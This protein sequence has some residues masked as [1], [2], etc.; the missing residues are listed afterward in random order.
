MADEIVY[1]IKVDTKSGEQAIKKIDEQAKTSG[2]SSGGIGSL[3][4]AIKGIGPAAVAAGAAMATYFV[5]QGLKAGIAAAIET[6]DAIAKMNSALSMA[7]RLSASTS[8][9]MQDFAGYIQKTTIVA[10]DAALSYLALATAFTKTN[11]QTKDM[12]M[13]AINLSTVMGTS[14]DGAIKQLGGS[15]GGVTG[16]LARV[17][18]EIRNLTEEQLKAGAAID[19]VNKKFGGAAA[20]AAET[21][22][23]KIIQL[24]NSFGDVLE[25]I[26]FFFTKSD[27]LRRAFGYIATSVTNLVTKLSDFR[28]NTGDIFK[29]ILIGAG[30][31]GQAL[32]L[33]IL[34]PL[35]FVYQ[36]I[37]KALLP[38]TTL[39]SAAMEVMSGNF[40]GAGAII[41]SGLEQA[42]DM[43]ALFSTKG[44]EAALNWTQ[45]FID[46]VKM[47]EGII[48]ENLPE[49]ITPKVGLDEGEREK[50]VQDLS[51]IGI[52]YDAF[53]N[54]VAANQA[55]IKK[56]LQELQ[57]QLFTT[58]AQ[59]VSR[60]M[61]A[62]GQALV[63]GGNALQAFGRAILGMLGEMAMQMGMFFFLEGIAYMWSGDYA[64]G[65]GLIA[66]GL[67]LMAFGG[68]L[69]ALAGGGG[70]APSGAGASASGATSSGTTGTVGDS[71]TAMNEAP[72]RERMTNIEVNIAGNVLGDKRTLGIE[73][74]D[75]LN[76]AFGSDG[77]VIARG[78]IV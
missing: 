60:A 56:N 8:H 15:L 45:G 31:V 59:G 21:Y 25:E 51:M 30:Y 74:A 40:A 2:G 1:E 11:T 47:S 24:K 20:A 36:A 72:E 35:E 52:A 49:S 19:L 62:F 27:A 23:G 65:G 29:P 48:K 68:V 41:S 38:F 69:Q 71:T 3:T 34:R 58:F 61:N 5:A 4:S 77:I 32:I 18:P 43:G 22:S 44:T 76:E 28:A 6:E 54:K 64:R 67:G 55:A 78:A 66:A 50:T 57:K 12:T 17:I 75:A 63:T 42:L 33:L 9:E 53:A 14:V 16:Q 37:N 73:I 7:G 39:I 46:Q 10:D 26:G 13:A 70:G